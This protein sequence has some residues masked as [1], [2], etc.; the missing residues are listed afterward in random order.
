MVENQQV[1]TTIDDLAPTEPTQPSGE[2]E[3]GLPEAAPE[4]AAKR[5]RARKTAGAP[6]E[7]RIVPDSA[8]VAAVE[9]ARAAAEE[10]AGDT[11]GDYLGASVEGERVLTHSFASTERGYRGWRWAVTVARAPRARAVT[12]SEVVLLP[13]EGALLAPEWLTWAARL[14]P[15]DLGANDVLPYKGDDP[16]LDQGY[17]TAGDEDAD[18]LAFWELG[19]GRPR[20]LSREG[21][22]AAAE[23]WY[24]GSRG[25]A[26]EIALHASAAC[27]SCGYFL[28]LA[29]SLR[30]VFGVCGNEWSPEDGTVVSADH[31]CGAHSETD[32]EPYEPEPL[33]A[34]ILDETGVEAVIVTRHQ[35]TAVEVAPEGSVQEPVADPPAA[36]ADDDHDA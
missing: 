32:V 9:L 31:G 29:G 7:A 11:V 33:P 5:A 10:A 22:D 27:S 16:Y 23:R 3:P 18:E 6:R 14:A 1:L 24:R 12:V 35:E 28:Q 21:R 8:A 17:E 26:A 19:L 20:V 2:A 34:H 25:P 4:P 13:G 36:D 30:Q 15:G